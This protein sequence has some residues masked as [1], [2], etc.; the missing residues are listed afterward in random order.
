MRRIVILGTGNELLSDEGVGVHAARALQTELPSTEDAVEVIDGGTCPDICY[1][2]EGAEKLV[3]VDAVRGGCEPGTI[4]RFTPD[5][6]DADRGLVTS[7]HELGLLENLSLMDFAGGKPK[8]TVIIGVEPAELK[9]GLE[10]SRRLQDRMPRILE[11]VLR[12][13][14][15]PSGAN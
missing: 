10:L 14:R 11:T 13:I 8:E 2:V 5:Q 12:E 9:P 15:L 3:I 1:M 7:V 6:I 4:Y